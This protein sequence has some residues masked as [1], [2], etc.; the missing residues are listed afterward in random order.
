MNYTM[1]IADDNEENR[2]ILSLL[3]QDD[4]AI[5]QAKN[6]LETLTVLEQNSGSIDVVLLDLMMPDLDGLDVLRRR[7]ALPYFQDVPVVV[8]TASNAP[9]DQI[10]AFQLGAGDYI[11]KPFVPDIVRSRVKNVMA[12][13]RRRRAI[14]RQALGRKMQPALD[15]LTGLYNQAA[16]DLEI[17][18]VLQTRAQQ[19]HALLVIDIDNYQTV[20]ALSGQAAAE[21]TVRI[22]ADLISGL[23]RK[24]DIVGRMEG[25]AYVVLM[26]DVPSSQSVQEK[27]NTLI[28]LMKY[29]PNLT[30]PENVSVSVGYV[31]TDDD[32]RSYAQ[33]MACAKQALHAA[34]LAG[35]ACAR[36]YG[37]AHAPVDED[38]LH[39][40][41]LVSRNRSVCSMVQALMPEQLRVI[42][43]LTLADLPR[44]T[45]QQ[46][47]RIKMAYI[48][49]S[50]QED[51]AQVWSTISTYSWVRALPTI[52]VC[53]EGNMTQYRSA[54]AAGVEDILSAP[55]ESAVFRRRTMKLLGRIGALDDP[56]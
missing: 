24:S 10:M 29:K 35:K 43:V 1:L 52:A 17:T 26:T 2:D 15:L 25:D 34:K 7:A 41:L 31:I 13:H 44:V 55:L 11:N 3:F 48:D 22:V 5:L 20:K 14:A 38:A 16:A 32:A 46:I 30:I 53:E 39:A 27:A 47:A 28:Q 33:L 56:M 9:E 50:D 51:C 8:I 37:V 6:G 40:V 49:V 36:E 45:P 12:A 42:E 21:H 18:E 54:M 23:F 4:Y 19:R